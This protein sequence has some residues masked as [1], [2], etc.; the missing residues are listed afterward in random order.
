MTAIRRIPPYGDAPA[1]VQKIR[2]YLDH[3]QTKE[4]LQQHEL[5]LLGMECDRRLELWRKVTDTRRPEEAR[6]DAPAVI[7]NLE[8]LSATFPQM[9]LIIDA[10]NAIL[11]SA[12]LNE[13][14]NDDN[15]ISNAKAVFLK[16]CRSFLKDKFKKVLVVFDGVEELSDSFDPSSDDN[17]KI[18]YAKRQQEAH[19]ADLFILDYLSRNEDNERRWLVTDDYGLRNEAG[20]A[21]EANVETLA[22]HRLLNL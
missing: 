12:K 18:V 14:V 19:N 10:C 8:R 3:P 20:N 15:S 17:F 4:L 21:V 11:C 5:A 1:E 13:M 16:K 6:D 22:L 9:T 2:E 7:W